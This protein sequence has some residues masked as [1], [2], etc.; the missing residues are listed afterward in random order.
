VDEPV[1]VKQ[2]HLFANLRRSNGFRLYETRSRDDGMTWDV[3]KPSPFPSHNTPASIERLRNR[4]GDEL[5]VAWDY[6]GSLGRRA[7]RV[8]AGSGSFAGWR[9][10]LVEAEVDF[11]SQSDG[12]LSGLLSYDLSD[13]RRPDRDGLDAGNSAASFG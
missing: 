9:P 4:I 2:P 11:R 8:A 10:E 7:G 12:R 5:V 1:Q 3:P 6:L 13:W